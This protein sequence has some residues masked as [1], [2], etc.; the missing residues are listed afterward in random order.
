MSTSEMSIPITPWSAWTRPALSASKAPEGLNVGRK[1]HQE[2]E[3]PV[4]TNPGDIP[5]YPHYLPTGRL[6]FGALVMHA[7]GAKQR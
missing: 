6:L 3:G 2:Y 7:A 4:G 5:F 1:K